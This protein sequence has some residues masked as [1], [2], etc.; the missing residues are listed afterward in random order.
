VAVPAAAAGPGHI[1]KLP[2]EVR[3]SRGHAW[4]AA[5]LAAAT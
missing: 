2:A 3:L 4:T 1:S 5:A